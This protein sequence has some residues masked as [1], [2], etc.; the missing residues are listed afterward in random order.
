MD[1]L[2]TN[3]WR[4]PTDNMEGFIAVNLWLVD[5][6][7]R[8]SGGIGLFENKSLWDTYKSCVTPKSVRVNHLLRAYQS[9][10]VP[11]AYAA[12]L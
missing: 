5:V 4:L 3:I 7:E 9:E 11:S 8:F 12:R 2:L 1:S 10:G 6:A